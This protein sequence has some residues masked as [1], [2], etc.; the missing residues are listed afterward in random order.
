MTRR[1]DWKSKSRKRSDTKTEGVQK[2]AQHQIAATH[3]A[4]Q[5]RQDFIRT[6]IMMLLASLRTAFG[7]FGI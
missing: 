3:C 6:S 1:K 4:T 2:S 5:S 7:T